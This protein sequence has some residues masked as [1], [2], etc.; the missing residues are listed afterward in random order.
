MKKILNLLLVIALVITSVAFPR[1]VE[2]ARSYP[3]LVRSK[4]EAHWKDFIKRLKATK[5]GV[6]RGKK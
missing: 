5:V 4:T 2:A 1:P 3:N 6:K